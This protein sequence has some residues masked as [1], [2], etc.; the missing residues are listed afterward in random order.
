MAEFDSAEALGQMF[1]TS[2][3]AAVLADF[4]S[5]VS[6]IHSWV[7]SPEATGEQ[8]LRPREWQRTD[9]QQRRCWAPRQD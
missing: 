1:D 4:Q 2:E 6:D 5:H 3:W 8:P 9:Q 7:L